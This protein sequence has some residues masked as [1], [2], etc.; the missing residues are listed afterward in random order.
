MAVIALLRDRAA[1]ADGVG[2]LARRALAGSALGLV[3]LAVPQQAYF[4][5]DYTGLRDT[6]EEQIARFLRRHPGEA[7]FPW[8]PLPHLL[9]EGRLYHFAYGLFDRD[10]GGFRVTPD[11][12]ARFVPEQCRYVCFPEGRRTHRPPMC[13]EPWLRDFARR[14]D[15]PELPGFECYERNH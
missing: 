14:V 11:H 5:R 9:A 6:R 10:L 8:N 3:L 15:I 4:F 13:L 12:I 7:Y 2:S 1:S